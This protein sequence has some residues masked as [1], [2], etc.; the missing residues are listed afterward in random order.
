MDA[1]ASLPLQSSR[2]KMLPMSLSQNNQGMFSLTKTEHKRASINYLSSLNR[3][4]FR[5]DSK[6]FYP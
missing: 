6:T 5:S 2:N 4:Q 1:L 3:K